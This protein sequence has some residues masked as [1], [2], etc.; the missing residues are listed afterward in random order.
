M[1]GIEIAAWRK[2]FDFVNIQTEL[3]SKVAIYIPKRIDPKSWID[4][5]RSPIRLGMT[6]YDLI[7]ANTK[8]VVIP[9]SKNDGRKYI[10]LNDVAGS[11]LA[12]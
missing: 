5:H 2:H 3:K 6:R 7:S 12:K 1:T 4:L 10:G 8:S 9:N 11:I